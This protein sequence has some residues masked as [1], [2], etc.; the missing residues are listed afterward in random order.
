[1]SIQLA[2]YCPRTV[3]GTWAKAWNFLIIE[4]TMNRPSLSYDF[5]ISIVSLNSDRSMYFRNLANKYDPMW[6]FEKKQKTPHTGRMLFL[7]RYKSQSRKSFR[8]NSD[9][10]ANWVECWWRAHC[11]LMWKSLIAYSTKMLP[12][13]CIVERH[14]LAIC[15]S[16]LLCFAFVVL[17]VVYK[18]LN[19]Y[20]V[21][22]TVFAR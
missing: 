8:A 11:V 13:V 18:T 16:F 6:L 4:Y 15:P 17:V 21:R 19:I 9:W 20:V 14:R 3:S 7:S 1:M 12:F 2:F 5:L 22:S 10:C